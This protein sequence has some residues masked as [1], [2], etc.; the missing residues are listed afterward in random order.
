MST[1]AFVNRDNNR[2]M[3]SPELMKHLYDQVL[4][5]ERTVN[6]TNKNS[7]KVFLFNRTK[8]HEN[9]RELTFLPVFIYNDLPSKPSKIFLDFRGVSPQDNNDVEHTGRDKD[10][11]NVL[12]K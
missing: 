4:S 8:T 7:V 6:R 10:I 5:D 12:K 11:C 9:R 1:P 2:L 3:S